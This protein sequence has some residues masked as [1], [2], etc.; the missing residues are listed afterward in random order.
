[1]LFS[2]IK[3]IN[4]TLHL[5]EDSLYISTI[6]LISL[7]IENRLAHIYETEN[8]S[9]NDDKTLGGLIHILNT[10]GH[11]SGIYTPLNN[12][13]DIRNNIIHYHRRSFNFYNSFIESIKYL[14]QF[15][16]WCKN[17]GRL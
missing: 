7:F 3:N 10:Q 14:G 17:Y 15:L 6:A 9:Y 11:L 12:F 4:H 13:K 1:M 16:I 2:L 5:N 8:G